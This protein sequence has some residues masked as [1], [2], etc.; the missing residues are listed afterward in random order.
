MGRFLGIKI[1]MGE[2]TLKDVQDWWLAAVQ[3]WLQ[4]NPE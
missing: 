4:D 1:R 3:K 2:I